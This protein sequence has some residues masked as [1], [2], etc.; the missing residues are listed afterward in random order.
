MNN[1]V[2][3]CGKFLF[4]CS[5]RNCSTLSKLRKRTLVEVICLTFCFLGA[6]LSNISV[7]Q[8]QRILSVYPE[9][10][11]PGQTISLSG[12]GFQDQA[13]ALIWKG[14]LT[15]LFYDNHFVPSEQ[16]HD[17]VIS[18][19]LLYLV[20]KSGLQVVDVNDPQ[21]PKLL[22]RVETPGFANGLAI[23]GD[24]AYVADGNNG[25]QVIDISKPQ[26]PEL[27]G[28]VVAPAFVHEVAVA[29]NFAYVTGSFDGFQVIDI[30]N[31]QLPELVSIEGFDVDTHWWKIKIVG[32]FAYVA[33]HN[34]GLQII[35]IS[36]PQSPVVVGAVATTGGNVYGVDVANGFAYIVGTDG[37]QIIDISNPKQPGIAISV[38]KS[39]SATGVAHA[40]NFIVVATFDR[41][42]EIYDISWPELPVLIGNDRIPSLVDSIAVSGN[43]IYVGNRHGTLNISSLDI[44]LASKFINST[45]LSAVLPANLSPGR[46]DVIVVNPD[47]SS[48]KKS[49][50]LT[51]SDP[52]LGV[53]D[54]HL[55]FSGDLGLSSPAQTVT[56]TNLGNVNLELGKLRTTGNEFILDAD[57]CSKVTL[58]ADETCTFGVKLASINAG[59][60]MAQVSIPNNTYAGSNSI[61]LFSFTEGLPVSVSSETAEPGQM[62]LI[63]G[64]GFEEDVRAIFWG[65][66]PYI[67]GNIFTA[68]IAKD[69][70]IA[71]NYA[72]I[73]LE[74]LGLKVF[75]IRN[76]FNPMPVASVDTPENIDTITLAGDY[77]YLVGSDSGLQI[78]DVSNPA[79]PHRVG[80]IDTLDHAKTATIDGDYAYVIADRNLLIIDVS[81]PHAPL[82]ISSVATTLGNVREVAIKDDYAYVSGG[83][84]LE[85]IDISNPQAPELVGRVASAVGSTGNVASAGNYVLVT[86]YYDLHI[87]DISQP[88]QPELI[89]SITI[90]FNAGKIVI[91]GHYAYIEHGGNLSVIDF[92]DPKS[93]V[94]V[95]VL[96]SAYSITNF[97]INGRVAYITDYRKILQ[98]LDFSYL[99]KPWEIA[100]VETSGA[101]KQVEIVDNIAYVAEGSKGL[102]IIDIKKAYVPTVIGTIDTP[103]DVVSVSG[104]Y[105]YL[106]GD[107]NF[108]IL[109]INRPEKPEVLA[110]LA[111]S[112]IVEDIIIDGNYAFVAGGGSRYGEM[113][114]MDISN[115]QAPVIVDDA[116]AIAFNKAVDVTGKYEFTLKLLWYGETGPTDYRLVVSDISNPTEP[117]E[118]ATLQGRGPATDVV[119]NG[120]YAYIADNSS[121]LQVIDIS[122]P[123]KPV[124]IVSVYTEGRP[125]KVTIAES[126]AYIIEAGNGLTAMDISEPERPIVLGHVKIKSSAAIEDIL[127]TEKYVYLLNSEGLTIIPAAIPAATQFV[128]STT[129]QT[130]VPFNLTKRTYNLTVLN[131]DGGVYKQHNALTVLQPVTVPGDLDVDGDVDKDD[132][133]IILFTRNKP[134]SGK[135]DPRDLNEDGKITGLD[136]R[137]LVQICTRARCSTE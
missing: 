134:A 1:E 129:L 43:D 128:D 79:A 67:S 70:A 75:D 99:Q 38:D 41:G 69:I 33:A 108:Q 21:S 8:E 45:S 101:A 23:D 26:S 37:L 49:D 56:L 22:G 87:F 63:Q 18:G 52:I 77:A 19:N 53:S 78:V 83:S 9:I 81:R 96:N 3:V 71:D 89:S 25:M 13:R 92:S 73:V 84:G 104:N 121:S 80:G 34:S 60:K 17:L 20:D 86:T 42:L 28:S 61:E 11:T 125:K 119:I 126:I 62:I 103:T 30:S 58:A 120:H 100:T 59:S 122:N 6:S 44:L 137:K 64:E 7:A 115:P 109:D 136:A 47:G 72:Y 27:L 48:Y 29:G 118:V 57:N 46:Y 55:F 93:P 90:G 102:K 31:P 50:G 82:V 112:G 40:G 2:S 68:E 39:S 24:F 116:E 105:A 135:D 110:V 88:K 98:I 32:D 133:N 130:T 85:L 4:F 117:V 106:G 65:G 51:V 123:L 113:L 95:T 36:I 54:K 74:K 114:I 5:F 10:A 127:V 35:D 14:D 94:E 91:D 12:D 132:L 15:L 124:Y 97:D 76:P 16:I 111:L 66:G 107:G 131:G